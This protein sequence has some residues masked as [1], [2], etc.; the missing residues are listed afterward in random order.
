MV[1]WWV[2]IVSAAATM[3]IDW[4]IF[5]MV[6]NRVAHKLTVAARDAV[7][8][9]AEDVKA[10]LYA[11]IP[12][13]LTSASAALKSTTEPSSSNGSVPKIPSHG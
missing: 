3:V 10:G 9:G 12:S 6:G 13:L 1:H 4:V 11:M 7:M 8:A 5:V 2:A